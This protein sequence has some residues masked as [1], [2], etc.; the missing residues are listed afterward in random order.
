MST[1]QAPGTG[2]RRVP[3][4]AGLR[5][6]GNMGRVQSSEGARVVDSVSLAHELSETWTNAA[7]QL[8]AQD[9]SE[10]HPDAPKHQ[11]P[12]L[13]G[14]PLVPGVR[15]PTAPAVSADR[16]PRRL[17]RMPRSFSRLSEMRK[18]SGA[19]TASNSPTSTTPTLHHAQSIEH[20]TNRQHS[21]ST[22]GSNTTATP[23]LTG[24]QQP[25]S[26]DSSLQSFANEQVLLTPETEY[27]PEIPSPMLPQ[28]RTPSAASSASSD[29]RDL[30]GQTI[31]THADDV[32]AQET[33][34][35]MQS[36][37]G[38]MQNVELQDSP[39]K[40]PKVDNTQRRRRGT[41]AKLGHKSANAQTAQEGLSRGSNKNLRRL[42]KSPVQERPQITRVPSVPHLP[43]TAQSSSSQASRR[44]HAI[45]ELVNTERSYAADLDVARD[46]Y[47][48][49]AR[50]LAGVAPLA[51]MKQRPTL[52]AIDTS[53]NR[54]DAPRSAPP[55]T[56]RDMSLESLRYAMVPSPS[57][58]STSLTSSLASSVPLSGAPMSTADIS[59]VFAGLD[60]CASLA[61][62]MAAELDAAG[63]HVARVFL[64]NIDT[65]ER[66]YAYYCARHEAAAARLADLSN[67]PAA[68]AF[69]REC[70]EVARKYSTS[71]DLLSLLIKPVQ[72]VLK[73]PLLLRAIIACTP[74][75]SPD[76]VDLTTAAQQI[77]AAA[78]RINAYK[79][80]VDDV[81]LHGF[82]SPIPT[83]NGFRLN[84]GTLRLGR[85]NTRMDAPAID[86]EGILVTLRVRLTV[87]EERLD[88][89]AHECTT[90]LQ[91]ARERFVVQGALIDQWIQLY[92]LK[93]RP[94]QADRLHAY[95]AVLRGSLTALVMER[96][97][98]ELDR[99]I[100]SVIMDA[101][102]IVSRA[103][104]VAANRDAKEPEYRRYRS[105]LA[106]RPGLKPSTAVLA[107]ISLH[108][109]LLEE[110]PILLRHLEVLLDL[111]FSAFARIQTTY[112]MAVIQETS[113]FDSEARSRA[114]SAASLPTPGTGAVPSL[115]PT[116]RRPL[117]APPKVDFD[118]P[119]PRAKSTHELEPPLSL[120][121]HDQ[122]NRTPT[123]AP[124][125]SVQHTPPVWASPA[126]T[127][128]SVATFVSANEDVFSMSMSSPYASTTPRALFSQPQ[129][130]PAKPHDEPDIS[131]VTA[132]GHD[133]S[134]W[135]SA[136][137]LM[138][139]FDAVPGSGTS[140]PRRNSENVS[141]TAAA[142]ER[143]V[144]QFHGYTLPLSPPPRPPRQQRP[145]S[146]RQ[147][148][149]SVDSQM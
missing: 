84:S 16:K 97:E 140:P 75:T 49:H 127:I 113:M 119:T 133:I 35:H 25:R 1:G 114:F 123:T 5:Q 121:P 71:W 31:T 73:Y 44:T 108:E 37:T 135:S 118:A 131:M 137:E 4:S 78:N 82:S 2:V 27:A 41:P 34:T 63:E 67:V 143:P 87:H 72:R 105:E 81:G 92:E 122:T 74:T 26:R 148:Q 47:L 124:R 144:T 116:P 109:Q 38:T 96:L 117:G 22:L 6:Y 95:A 103:R 111:C 98:S 79:K 100:K 46:V 65:I 77:E 60:A 17:L 51:S 139:F 21:T 91:L 70:D 76:H 48:N 36:L 7:N 134:P 130:Y 126:P 23:T 18:Q 57:T 90:W 102:L 69:L 129:T 101:H 19:S 45:R 68:A 142:G 29:L 93:G 39:S 61:N 83:R 66:V 115:P 3:Q 147:R 62:S 30:E 52:T 120:V 128:E 106:R 112:H 14:P 125:R 86:T 13:F 146:A 149:Y 28:P 40:T 94:P 104:M 80:R 50:L 53:V 24:F 43:D 136:S 10:Y 138:T 32:F 56:S 88:S 132:A 64:D 20:L 42:F 9:G 58:S 99:S 54:V 110:L 145:L 12:V 89:F 55:D 107:F 141:P 59:I 8:P 33:A 15:A 85:Q 11:D